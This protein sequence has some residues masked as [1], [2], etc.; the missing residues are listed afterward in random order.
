MSHPDIITTSI[1]D[2]PGN[3][4]KL[5]KLY[6]D[7]LTFARIAAALGQGISREACIGKAHRLKL[8]PRQSPI[9]TDRV[10]RKTTPLVM[11][12][13]GRAGNP[14]QPKVANIIHR[15]EGRQ[16]IERARQVGK[17]SHHGQVPFR[18]AGRV[19]VDN[20][21]VD[22]S[23]LIGI[24]DLNAHTCRWP[25]GDPQTPDFGFCGKHSVE[26]KPY[27]EDHCRRAFNTPG[28]A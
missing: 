17:L 24:M 8:P 20:D 23:S 19:D 11:G 25:I 28:A 16:K 4:E 1:W 6:F 2:E 13:A 26:G 21:G 7:G 14:G 15:I 12:R 9:R 22:V 5:T 10:S 3:T 27:C 18:A